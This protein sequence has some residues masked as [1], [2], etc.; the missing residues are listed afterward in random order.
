VREQR[1]RHLRGNGTAADSVE[2]VR[3]VEARAVPLVNF[4]HPVAVAVA[5][6]DDELSCKARWNCPYWE[7]GGLERFPTAY[8]EWGEG[9]HQPAET[10]ARGGVSAC[11]GGGGG[12]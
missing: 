4:E 9:V 2:A 11:L 6:Y 3:L 7:V 10:P 8:G 12:I 5:S 1:P